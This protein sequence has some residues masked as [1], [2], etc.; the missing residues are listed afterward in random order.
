MQE[1]INEINNHLHL[2]LQQA[3]IL[4]AKVFAAEGDSEMH[5][6]LSS[7]LVPNLTH[8]LTGAQAGSIKDLTTTVERHKNE[9]DRG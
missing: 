5:R 7:Y 3:Q 1:D 2:A 9:K 6:K 4:Q 8:W